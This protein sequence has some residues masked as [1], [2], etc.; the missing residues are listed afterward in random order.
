MANTPEPWHFL[1]H[2][3]GSEQHWYW[4][5]GWHFHSTVFQPLYQQLAG[6]H[7]GA[8]YTVITHP[9]Q[10]FQRNSASHTIASN[11]VFIGW[12]LG[13]AVL[14]DA[15]ILKNT[16]ISASSPEPLPLQTA[17]TIIALAD[18]STISQQALWQTFISQL[19]HSTNMEDVQPL[20]NR[21]LQ[22]CLL[23]SRHRRTLNK[24]LTGHRL[25][26][27]DT[28][29]RSLQWLAELSKPVNA[30]H[31]TAACSYWHGA[32]DAITCAP[33]SA[34]MLGQSHAFF[35]EPESQLT[36]LKELKQW[37]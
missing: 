33:A 22:L 20:L 14:K 7:W 2:T 32:H 24:W 17:R 23:G 27:L 4:L 35:L 10:L 15:A 29:K 30:I 6:Y 31:T 13:A 34:T 11:A 18:T 9:E 28:L 26:D 19:Q 8:D 21:F 36:L 5:P 37:Q 25:Y 1:N 3:P 16:A 12:S